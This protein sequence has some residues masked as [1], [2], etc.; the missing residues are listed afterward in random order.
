MTEERR[1]PIW[2]LRDLVCDHKTGKLRETAV[3]SILCKIAMTWGFVY[4]VY[5][6]KANF[7]ESLWLAYGSVMLGHEAYARFMNQRQQ[8]LDKDTPNA[9][10]TRPV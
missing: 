3:G 5:Q 10:P 9:Q 6:Q 8:K 4:T 2:H 1:K 7:S